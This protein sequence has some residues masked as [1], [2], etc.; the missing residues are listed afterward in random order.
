MRDVLNILGKGTCRIPNCEGCVYERA[1][2]ITILGA[3]YAR[4]VGRAC[5][6]CKGHRYV[7]PAPGSTYDMDLC[8]DCDGTGLA[9]GFDP[10][11]VDGEARP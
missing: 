1:E 3:E 9:N 6:R 7:D 11:E 8:P 2:A 5:A 10:L 4:F